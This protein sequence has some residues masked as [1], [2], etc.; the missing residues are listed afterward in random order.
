[1][2]DYYIHLIYLHT[3]TLPQELPHPQE[4]EDFTARKRR[5]TREETIYTRIWKLPHYY[6]EI[7]FTRYN[8]PMSPLLPHWNNKHVAPRVR[9]P[10]PTRTGPPTTHMNPEVESE[11]ARLRVITI[12][13]EWPRRWWQQEQVT[14]NAVQLSPK[15]DCN[16]CFEPSC[17]HTCASL[18]SLSFARRI[19]F[20]KH[21]PWNRWEKDA[22]Q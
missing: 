3:R 13:I 4:Q 11:S 22:Y 8:I 6:Q 10:A 15:P 9:I 12:T 16:P 21:T 5:T 7:I 1:M 14:K 18:F 20:S 2:F 19:F 17:C